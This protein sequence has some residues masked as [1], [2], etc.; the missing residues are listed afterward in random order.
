VKPL[1]RHAFVLEVFRDRDHVRIGAR[2]EGR[3][4]GMSTG[5]LP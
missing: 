2:R 1:D 3:F 5:V 4:F